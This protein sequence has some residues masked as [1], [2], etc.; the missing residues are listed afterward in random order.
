MLQKSSGVSTISSTIWINRKTN[1]MADTITPTEEQERILSFVSSNRSTNVLVQALAGAAKTTTLELVAKR[2]YDKPMMALAFNVRIAEEMRKRLP[3]HCDCRTMNSVGHRAWGSYIGKKLIVEKSK[4][5][6]IFRGSY[7]NTSPDRDEAEKIFMDSVQL[8]ARAKLFGYIPEGKY[9]AAVHL[10]PRHIL[11]D[12]LADEEYH[13]F[14]WSVLDDLLFKSIDM[15]YAG[16]IDY[17]DQV[18]M[19]TLFNAPFPRFARTLVDEAQDLSPLN[20]YMI[21]RL[22]QDRWVM[23]VGDR[24]QS[25]YA[26]RGAITDGLQVLKERFKMEELTLSISFR[27]PISVVRRAQSRAPKMQ[28]PEWAIEGEVRDLTRRMEVGELRLEKPVWGP[29]LFPD[30]CAVICRNNAPLFELGLKLIRAGRGVTIRGTDISKRL[31]KV[32]EDLGESDLPQ[33]DV[34]SGVDTWRIN[35]L[36]EGKLRKETIEDRFA[37]LMVFAEAGR[38]LGDAIARAKALFAQTGPIELL[39]GHKAKGLEWDHVFHL[40]CW[41]IPSKYARE[42][43]GEAL[44]QEKNLDYVITTRAKQTLTLMNLEHFDIEA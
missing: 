40:D 10:T 26:F 18:Y 3:G 9:D 16:A 23:A 7:K 27:C 8:A 2:L 11:E 4:M 22:V 44:E 41:R 15:A 6:S 17:D 19:P 25:I 42:M 24:F 33:E 30:G 5:G 37:C 12:A 34:I 21:S 43:G 13:S 31:I 29:S 20:H 28:W 39:S 36:N 14:A 35:K 1:A 32:L 38:N